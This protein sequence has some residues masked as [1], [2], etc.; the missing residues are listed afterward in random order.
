MKFNLTGNLAGQLCGDCRQPVFPAVIRLYR[1]NLDRVTVTHVAAEIKDTLQVI[2]RKDV[3]RLEKQLL[4][5]GKTDAE[6]NYSIEIDGDKND[7][8]GEPVLVVVEIP[9]LDPME[10]REDKHP[11]QFIALTT[12]QPQWQYSNDQQNAFA[13]FKYII[14]SP[15]WCAL[16]KHFD[17]WLICGRIVDCE[18]P[19]RPVPGVKVSAMDADCL[20]DDFLGDATTDA[21]GFFRIAYRSKDFKQTFLSP[22]INVETPFSR[23]LGP[24]VY[25]KVETVDGDVLLEEGRAEGKSDGRKDVSNCFCV[26][27]CVELDGEPGQDL[28][29][30]LSWD[31]IGSDFTIS[32]QGNPQDFDNDGYAEQAGNKY[33]ITG[34]I[35]LNG[36]GPNPLLPGNPVEYRFRISKNTAS[37]AAASLP[38]GDFSEIVG[39]SPNL[40]RSVH[41]GTLRRQAPTVRFVNVFLT[42]A[43]IDAQGWVDVRAAVNRSLTAHAD[44]SPADLNDP[45]QDWEWSDKDPMIGLNTR[46]LTNEEGHNPPAGLKAGDAVPGGNRY[47]IEKV[48][49]RFEIRDQVTQ[50]PLA[51]NGTTLN[52]M[53]VNNDGPVIRLAV[54]NAAGTEVVCDKFKNEDVFI[55]YTAYHPHLEFVRLNVRSNSGAYNVNP[56]DAPV[57]FD[58]VP[59]PG[60]DHVNNPSLMLVPRPNT[61]CNYKVNLSYRVL[62]HNGESPASG[63]TASEEFYYEV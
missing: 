58:N 36:Q 55:A 1:A 37:N 8:Q 26:R 31:S 12:I 49:I 46:P 15:F 23:V 24:D 30:T 54:K 4:A 2:D 62:L 34:N 61:T 38:A 5:I 43:D 10:G 16:L 6:G 14:P 59:R 50:A 21:N 40:F 44:F 11:A 60:I 47:P 7:Y 45:A 39:V 42:S 9:H 63:H 35:K 33:A 19:K 51:A 3:D 18:D 52:A 29:Y 57:P 17:V 41:I 56:V 48:A 13:E 20:R 22:L 27:L 28:P 25:F 32:F 53:V